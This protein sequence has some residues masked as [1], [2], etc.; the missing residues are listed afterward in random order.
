MLLEGVKI[1]AVYRERLTLVSRA[2]EWAYPLVQEHIKENNMLQI[3]TSK[4]T[5]YRV[6]RHAEKEWKY[7]ILGVWLNIWWDIAPS[8]LCF[9]S[10]F[11]LPTDFLMPTPRSLCLTAPV[12]SSLLLT[13]SYF[14]LP[15]VSP[16][17][18]LL[19]SD[20]FLIISVS[21]PSIG[22]LILSLPPN[23]NS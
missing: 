2:S 9:D 15:L 13:H 3:L 4:D 22:F 14:C 17:L 20:S 1:S 16:G 7:L 12:Y 6:P 8:M 5:H 18:F 23:V 19:Y 11:L 21:V 10:L